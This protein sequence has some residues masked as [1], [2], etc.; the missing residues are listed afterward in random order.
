M[1]EVFS[2]SFELHQHLSVVFLCF[3]HQHLSFE[4]IQGQIV[5]DHEIYRDD[6]EFNLEACHLSGQLRDVLSGEGR[7]SSPIGE[8]KHSFGVF[9]HFAV[10]VEEI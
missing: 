8:E 3:L 7:R 2:L 5:A 10:V 9:L 4:L 6:V 1:Y